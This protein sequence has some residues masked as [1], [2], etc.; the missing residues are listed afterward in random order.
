MIRLEMTRDYARIAEIMTHPKL[1]PW[2]ADD[3]YPA[4]ENFWPLESDALVHLLAFDGD[5][6][7]GLYITHPIN[8]RLWEVHHCLLPNAWGRRSIEVGRAFETWLWENT[9]AAKVIGFTP[10]DNRLALRY[11]K[12]LGMK[13]AGKVTSAL[14][15]RFE[16]HDI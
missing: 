11:A 4:P 9:Q 1:Y 14:Q 6:C 7:L 2:I 10:S 8:T 15:R 5:E 3:F 12:K 13:E 16:L